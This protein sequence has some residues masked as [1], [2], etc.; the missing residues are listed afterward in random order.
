[1]I[2]HF[3]SAAYNKSLFLIL[4]AVAG[5][6]GERILFEYMNMAALHLS[7]ADEKTGR[8]KRGE[9]RTDQ[10]RAFLVD[11]LRFFRFCKGFVIS[12]AV[13]HIDLRLF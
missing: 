1:M 3:P 6:A 2:F 10:I 5:A 12:A 4:N 9:S 11:I 13:I 8:R 7:V